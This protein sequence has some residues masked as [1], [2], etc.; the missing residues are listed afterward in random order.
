MITFDVLYN[1]GFTT[2]DD[3]DSPDDVMNRAWSFLVGLAFPVG[4]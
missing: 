3:S 4:G 2:L 1:F